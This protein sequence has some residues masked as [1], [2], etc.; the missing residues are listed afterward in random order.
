MKAGEVL[1][2]RYA[3]QDAISA[4]KEN[5]LRSSAQ[6]GVDSSLYEAI[7]YEEN[8]H[9]V[10]PLG[11][12]RLIEDV[13]PGS[14]NHG[15]GVMQASSKTSGISNRDLLNDRAN[16]DAGG[17]ILS[18]IEGRYGGDIGT[19]GSVYNS[20]GVTSARGGAYGQRLD[21]YAAASLSP[22]FGDGV[23]KGVSEG[24][25]NSVG[26]PVGQMA[27]SSLRVLSNLFSK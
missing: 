15:I 1:G 8:A 23:T 24:V 7:I 9:Q 10:P 14:V 26:G 11:I 6:T 12:E 5:I 25:K 2:G 17:Q 18:M 13:S 16:I 20:G 22:T 4:N 3:A 19:I 21:S 27:R